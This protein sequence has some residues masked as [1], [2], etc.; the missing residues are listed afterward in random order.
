L[1]L[2]DEDTVS[3]IFKN[4]ANGNLDDVAST[5]Q[6]ITLAAANLNP[7]RVSIDLEASWAIYTP[8]NN[9]RTFGTVTGSNES[10]FYS[11]YSTTTKVDIYTWKIIETNV[12]TDSSQFTDSLKVLRPQEYVNLTIT[13]KC[14][15]IVGDGRIWFFFRATEYSTSTPITDIRTI[16][17]DQ[18][19]NLY[20]SKA[21]GPD[22]TKYW[23]PLH[24]SYDPYDGDIGTGHAFNQHSWTRVPTIRVFSKANKMVH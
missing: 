19:M 22:Q 6:N 16:P 14:K 18:R 20:Y 12:Y 24:N 9:T 5:I 17:E 15:G 4:S 10:D 21:P 11:P 8:D 3:I 2:N 23:W 13:I 7:S 1:L